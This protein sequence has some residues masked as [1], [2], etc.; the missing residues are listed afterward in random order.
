[1]SPLFVQM[2]LKLKPYLKRSNSPPVTS[3][4]G[5]LSTLEGSASVI[6][7]KISS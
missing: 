5:R 6:Q 3:G 1:M 2:N 4:K 7:F